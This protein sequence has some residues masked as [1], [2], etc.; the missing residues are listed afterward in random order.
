M[1]GSIIAKHEKK[2]EKNIFLLYKL[3]INFETTI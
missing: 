3:R 2:Q 1:S